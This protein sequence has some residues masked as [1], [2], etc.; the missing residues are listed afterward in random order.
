MGN[1]VEVGNAARL[2]WTGGEESGCTSEGARNVSENKIPKGQFT[3]YR[4]CYGDF[5]WNFEAVSHSFF[6]QGCEIGRAGVTMSIL[7]MRNGGSGRKNHWP[8]ATKGLG[9]Q[10][11]KEMR[12]HNFEASLLPSSHPLPF[13]CMSGHS[14]PI[15]GV[16]YPIFSTLGGTSR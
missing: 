16:C 12:P 6:D 15:K 13:I 9:S 5:C 8:K 7:W 11:R 4:P 2:I 10:V 3:W 1:S 14:Y